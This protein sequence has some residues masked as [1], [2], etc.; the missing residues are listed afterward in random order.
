MNSALVTLCVLPTLR[1]LSCLSFYF[2]LFTVIT[3]IMTVNYFEEYKMLEKHCKEHV[4]E[5]KSS[6]V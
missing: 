4:C 1:S 6:Q 5:P 2:A 3:F